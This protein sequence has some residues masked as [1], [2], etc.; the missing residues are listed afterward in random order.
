MAYTP[1]IFTYY[2][3]SYFFVIRNTK[4]YIVVARKDYIVVV[5]KPIPSVSYAAS[6]PYT[7]GSLKK[8][9]AEAKNASAKFIRFC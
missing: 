2:I 6:F 4:D 1:N 3:V 8:E 7:K 5:R 9:K